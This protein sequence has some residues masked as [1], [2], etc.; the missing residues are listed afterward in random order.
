MG[1]QIRQKLS[2]LGSLFA[3]D[4]PSPTG[5]EGRSSCR[6]GHFSAIVAAFAKDDLLHP[7]EEV[8]V[9]NQEGPQGVFLQTRIGVG[10]RYWQEKHRSGLPD[11]V[12]L[13][14]AGSYAECR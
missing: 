2:S 1:L 7:R 6:Q 3:F 12:L 4:A 9:R 14:T 13:Q 5:C 8:I 10:P 11:S